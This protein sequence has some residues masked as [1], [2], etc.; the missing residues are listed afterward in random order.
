MPWRDRCGLCK[1]AVS[2]LSRW[3]L[4]GAVGLPGQAVIPVVLGL[5]CRSPAVLA[6]RL[7]PEMRDRVIAVLL[8]SIT[9]PCAATL[10]VVSA[11][12][13]RFGASAG[14][15]AGTVGASFLILAGVA[16]AAIPG[17]STPILIEVPPLRSPSLFNVLAKTWQ[18]MA[19]FFSHVLPLLVSMNVVIRLAVESGILSVP[20]RLSSLTLPL[21][22]VRVEVL[23]GVATTAIQRYIAPL[24]LMNLDL[25]PREATLACVM[26]CLS[27]PCA[28]VITL[29]LREIGVRRTLAIFLTGA[30]M[31]LL[32][33]VLLNT[34]LP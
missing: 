9:V 34:L 24:V 26:V 13:G 20:P 4:T 17:K 33:A 22:G 30:V 18:R 28:P 23:M 3:R 31:P 16:N 8:L 27:F 5:G 29:S 19:G 32:A 21:F 15:I 10:G 11:V 6:T 2:R 7:L 14:V 1:I 25:T 12:V